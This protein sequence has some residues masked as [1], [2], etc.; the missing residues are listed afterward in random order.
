M[1]VLNTSRGNKKGG[2][3]KFASGQG[4]VERL[5]DGLGHPSCQ[6][7]YR[8]RCVASGRCENC[9]EAMPTG[10]GHFRC[11]ECLRK[12]AER[13]HRA[14]V[15]R[16]WSLGA[17]EEQVA[18]LCIG[19][20]DTRRLPRGWKAAPLAIRCGKCGDVADVLRSYQRCACGGDL[21]GGVPSSARKRW[22]RLGDEERKREAIG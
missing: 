1:G 5:E 20:V 21:W 22:L 14:R 19:G 6:V 15:L 3:G 17:P 7:R 12:Q 16:L 13:K 2:R 8:K 9:G 10:D 11:S 18:R 4:Y